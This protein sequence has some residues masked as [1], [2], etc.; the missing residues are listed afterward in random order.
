MAAMTAPIR[1]TSDTVTTVIR[2]GGRFNPSGLPRSAAETAEQKNHA[3]LIQKSVRCAGL[4][5]QIV[6]VIRT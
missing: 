5:V 2:S 3:A 6:T 4:G 1:I